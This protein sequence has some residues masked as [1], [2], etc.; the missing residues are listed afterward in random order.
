MCFNALDRHVL[1]GNGNK[2]A[3]LFEG[4]DIGVDRRLTYQNM[5]DLVCQVCGFEER[6]L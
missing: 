5:L 2:A 6:F 4:N 1:S 3:I